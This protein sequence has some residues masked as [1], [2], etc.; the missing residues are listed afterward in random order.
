MI[1]GIPAF[2]LGEH[3]RE[4]SPEEGKRRWRWKTTAPVTI[5][6]AFDLGEEIAFIDGRG[7]ERGRLLGN[8]LKIHAGYAWNGCSPKRWVPVLGWIGTPDTADNLL[9]SFVHDFLCQFVETPHFPFSRDQVDDAFGAILR[10]S[11]FK[12]AGLYAGAVK[13]F[14]PLFKAAGDGSRSVRVPRQEEQPT[15]QSA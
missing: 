2:R 6:L 15:P 11:G 9:G 4:L 14:G 7:I 5:K 13:D 1:A 3:F 10:R 12:W 8:R